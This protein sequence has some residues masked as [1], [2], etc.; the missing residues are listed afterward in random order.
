ML[1]EDLLH[2]SKLSSPSVF[3]FRDLN[4]I[5]TEVLSDLELTMTEKQVKVNRK[6]LPH[7]DVYPGLIRQL[8]QNLL[9]NAFK[10]SRPGVRPEI[11]ISGEFTSELSFETPA[12]DEGRFCRLTISDNGIG[13]NPQYAEKIFSMFQRLHSKEVYEGT[14]IGLTIVKKIVEKHNGIIRAQS[15]DDQGAAFIMVFPVKQQK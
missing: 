11:Q 6:E 10:F 8:F 7:M 4:S 9:S 1:I 14:G 13:F 3:E 15:E 2:Y 5:V 12:V